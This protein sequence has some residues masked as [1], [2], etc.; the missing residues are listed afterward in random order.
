MATI[1]G[2]PM[3]HLQKL[4]ALVRQRRVAL[5]FT[6]KEAA[7]D[8][9]DISHTTYRKIEGADGSPP[10]RVRSTTYAKLD[11][12]MGFRSGSSEAVA[13][14]AADSITLLDGTELIEGGQ[15]RDFVQLGEEIDRAFDKSAQLTA[16]H[17]TLSEA[18]AMKDEMLRQLTERGVL[19]S[20]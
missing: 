2:D 5:G 8:A 17:L 1:S 20:D 15:I 14:G 3:R 12:G 4:A 10:R 18:K 9:C 6:S 16:P 7:A 11:L 13:A 19:K